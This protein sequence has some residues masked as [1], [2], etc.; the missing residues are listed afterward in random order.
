MALKK[1]LWIVVIVMFVVSSQ[2]S[3]VH[4]RV[5]RSEALKAEVTEDCEDFITFK[6]SS[7]EINSQTNSTGS[8]SSRGMVSFVVDSNNSST[9]P[10]KR[11]LSFVLASGPS[12]RG[13][14]H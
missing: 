12:K 7:P 6:S 3:F 9:R 5:L 8:N 2:L 4:S 10:S 14:G 1:G 11:S 13:R